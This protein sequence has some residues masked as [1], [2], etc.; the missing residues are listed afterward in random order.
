MIFY[1]LCKAF[2]F[3]TYGYREEK[4]PKSRYFCSSL[5]VSIM[6]P[7]TTTTSAMNES[8]SRPNFILVSV[9]ENKL[10]SYWNFSFVFLYDSSLLKSYWNHAE[11]EFG[12]FD[13]WNH[14]EIL[15]DN[16]W[17]ISVWFQEL[18]KKYFCNLID[19]LK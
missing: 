5:A 4:N 9:S 18:K 15:L 17:M 3:V 8:L 19:T 16:F 13:V 12:N 10:K 6:H 14:L 11:S 7:R 2:S 1:Y